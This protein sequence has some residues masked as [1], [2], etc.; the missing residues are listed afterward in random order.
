MQGKGR[1]PEI[2]REKSWYQMKVI[3]NARIRDLDCVHTK[4]DQESSLI[5]KDDTLSG[6]GPLPQQSAY[7]SLFELLLSSERKKKKKV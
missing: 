4:K 1:W 5:Y 7:Y 6:S 3:F 2:N